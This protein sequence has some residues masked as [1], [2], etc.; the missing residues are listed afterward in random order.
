M[1]KCYNQL[2]DWISKLW[3]LMFTVFIMLQRKQCEQFSHFTDNLKN[4]KWKLRQ[5]STCHF[6]YCT[7]KGAYHLKSNFLARKYT[8]LCTQS[9]WECR[10]FEF[11]FLRC[12]KDM[13][14][15]FFQTIQC[16]LLWRFLNHYITVF[17]MELQ[18]VK[19]GLVELQ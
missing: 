10:K 15:S 11:C 9:L 2:G 19:E 12:C 6:T 16:S 8:L 4:W 5:H 7:L 3:V 13:F 17:A 14:G 18:I 1:C